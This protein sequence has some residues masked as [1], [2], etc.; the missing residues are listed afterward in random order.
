MSRV[1][2]GQTAAGTP[3]PG[4]RAGWHVP[5]RDGS[6]GDT[7]S[8]VEARAPGL[9]IVLGEAGGSWKRRSV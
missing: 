8:V 1:R 7:P 5:G 9:G 4:P 3:G 2:S 6:A